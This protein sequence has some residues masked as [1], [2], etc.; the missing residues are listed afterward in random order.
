M[1]LMGA[2]PLHGLRSL[3]IQGPKT[4]SLF[5][6]H[7]SLPMAP[8]LDLTASNSLLP[9]TYK[10]QVHINSCMLMSAGKGLVEAV[11]DTF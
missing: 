3:P 5:R 6:A 10:Q 1:I 2:N 7:P 9:M 11:I 4:V 8:V